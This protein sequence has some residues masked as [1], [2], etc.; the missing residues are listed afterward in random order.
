MD[1]QSPELS[2]TQFLE[3]PMASAVY[4]S[5]NNL[6][7]T[8]IPPIGNKEPHNTTAKSPTTSGTTGVSSSAN[9]T[10]TPFNSGSS[11]NTAVTSI[12]AS[13]GYCDS[14]NTAGTENG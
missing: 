5:P 14:L 4:S 3:Q 1:L 7:N 10:T 6:N 12:S 2:Q 9:T 8:T 13:S 11:S